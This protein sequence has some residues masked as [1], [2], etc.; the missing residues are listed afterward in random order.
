MKKISLIIVSLFFFHICNSKIWYVKEGG[1]G[2]KDGSSWNNAAEDFPALLQDPT[3]NQNS[4]WS[5][6]GRLKPGVN[7]TIF[8]AR[9]S[10]SPIVIWNPCDSDSVRKVC[11]TSYKGKIK[12]YG[13]F[14]GKETTLS[15]RTNWT[16]NESIIN[17]DNQY[18]CLWIENQDSIHNQ[19]SK[20]I[21]IDGF[22]LKNGYGEGAAVRIVHNSPL[23]S[24]LNITNNVGCPIL[25][26]ENCNIDIV[27]RYLNKLLVYNS[28]I[29]NN[30]IHQESNVNYPDNIICFS[31]SNIHFMN[32]T[33]VFNRHHNTNS[34]N[35]IGLYLENN[36]YISVTNSIFYFNTCVKVYL[37]DILSQPN[38]LQF[39]FSDVQNSRGSLNWGFSPESDAGFNIDKD[40]IFMDPHNFNY[41]IN[42]NSPCY[43]TANKVIYDS[44]IRSIPLSLSHF[45]NYDCYSNSRVYDYYLDIGACEFNP[46]Y[47]LV[48]KYKDNISDILYNYDVEGKK[49]YISKDIDYDKVLIFDLSGKCIYNNIFSDSY[50]VYLSRGYYILNLLKDKNI[51]NSFKLLI[52]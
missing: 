48:P 44:L 31:S 25:W 50:N 11:R 47:D 12:I 49:L 7:D 29:S 37:Y 32:S 27:D 28:I 15:D 19:H 1:S 39:N 45:Y 3:V 17:G 26:F 24:N 20:D 5:S 30:V 36:S 34:I 4:L 40:P 46:D 21:V 2:I 14:S 23:L 43:N 13:G 6:Q 41:M 35:Y 9:G 16:I 38:I 33:I 42:K 18:S 51:V 8:V 10:Y 52:Y 22:T